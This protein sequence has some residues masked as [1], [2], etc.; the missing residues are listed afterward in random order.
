MCFDTHPDCDK[1]LHG[2]G[3]AGRHLQKLI[4]ARVC[5]FACFVCVCMWCLLEPVDEWLYT[6]L[7]ERILQ[8]THVDVEIVQQ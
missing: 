5:V 1:R 4:T 6:G 7:V 8:N 2:E 3:F